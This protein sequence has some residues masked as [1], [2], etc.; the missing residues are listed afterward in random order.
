MR[1]LEIKRQRLNTTYFVNSAND[2]NVFYSRSN[3]NI[4]IIIHDEHPVT[5]LLLINMLN[6]EIENATT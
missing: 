3:H 5:C 6:I 4:N 1:Q 2:V